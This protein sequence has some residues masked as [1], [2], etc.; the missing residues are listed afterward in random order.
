MPMMPNVLLSQK[1]GSIVE[2]L[3]GFPLHHSGQSGRVADWVPDLFL[4]I[5]FMQHIN[6]QAKIL[7]LLCLLLPL[8]CLQIKQE[9]KAFYFHDVS[10]LGVGGTVSFVRLS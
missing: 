8:F 4:S 5:C 3:S 7:L 10:K 1:S 6:P 2:V 9:V